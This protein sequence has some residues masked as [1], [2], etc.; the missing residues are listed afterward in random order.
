MM[1]LVTSPS[2]LFSQFTRRVSDLDWRLLLLILLPLS[3]LFYASLSTISSAFIGGATFV[4]SPLRSIFTVVDSLENLT[5]IAAAPLPAEVITLRFKNESEAK[6]NATVALPRRSGRKVS[7][8]GSKIAVC[9]VGGAR[10]FELTGPSIIQ[11]ILRV[12]PKSDLFLHSPL[13][14]NS[15]K[16]SL[17][18]NAPRIA[19]VK[20]FKP[21]R[22]NETESQAR[23]LTARNSPN[24]IQGLLQYFNLVEGCLTMIRAFQTKNNFT[25][26]WIVRTRVDG[27]WSHPLAPQNF[28]P[29]H[30]V[31]PPGSSYGG[32]NDRIGIGDFN[33]SVVALSRLSM[34]PQL[35]AGGHA[36]LNS[37]SA[38]KAQLTTQKV[39]YKTIR[40]PF[41][42]V[43]DR[44]YPF[45]PGANGVPVAA[46]SSPG[47]L[48]G[49]K[50]RPCKPACSRA[51]VPPVMSRLNKLW[52]WTDWANNTI[53]L[54]DAH[55]EWE[56]GWEKLFDEV[57]GKKLGAARKRVK[58]LSVQGCIRDFK[59]MK[60]KSASWKAPSAV[61]ICE[62]GL[63]GGL[64]SGTVTG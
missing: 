1:N 22:I 61:E 47:P 35:D 21:T 32:L 24:G 44:Q 25:Y 53:E 11:N 3:L 27:Y 14:S 57:A 23:V 49:A 8:D 55:G 4:T 40:L 43:T 30:Y 63:L 31:V 42:V 34:I 29:G 41:C 9:L 60:L 26:Q 18:R 48:S 51:C 17:L 37:E 58:K 13:D 12:Y 56:E 15:Y 5:A 64:K 46:L 33:T 54:C 59:A 19:A 45:P 2:K 16:L 52:S 50:C 62:L 39:P 6:A 36:Q 20:I 38:F 7:L 10:R 28:I